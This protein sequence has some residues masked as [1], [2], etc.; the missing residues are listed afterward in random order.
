MRLT[1]AALRIVQGVV[2]CSARARVFVNIG[3]IQ[4]MCVCDGC[5]ERKNA[6]ELEVTKAVKLRHISL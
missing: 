5:K 4:C 3:Y 1:W 6:L 2:L